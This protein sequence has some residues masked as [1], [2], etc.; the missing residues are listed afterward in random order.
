M[1]SLNPSQEQLNNFFENTRGSII[2]VKQEMKNAVSMMLSS[3][4]LWLKSMI[5]LDRLKHYLSAQH[6]TKDEII[7]NIAN[8]NEISSTINPFS[9]WNINKRFSQFTPN[10]ENRSQNATKDAME[11]TPDDQENLKA[12]QA[13]VEAKIY[14]I[15]EMYI[16]D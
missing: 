16:E 15:E 14:E 10:T 13:K 9:V 12:L 6:T 5:K 2:E 1:Y 11:L 3:R 4:N 7:Q 8:S